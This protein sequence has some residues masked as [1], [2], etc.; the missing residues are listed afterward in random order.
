MLGDGIYRTSYWPMLLKVSAYLPLFRSMPDFLGERPQERL[1]EART[2]FVEGLGPFL[3]ARDASITAAV[4]TYA[5]P[6]KKIARWLEAKSFFA[7]TRLCDHVLVTAKV[8][9]DVGQ[10]RV[11]NKTHHIDDNFV[12][13]CAAL[14]LSEGVEDALTLS[15]LAFPGCITVLDGL[16]VSMGSMNPI[17]KKNA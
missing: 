1:L 17:S 6:P 3:R 5:A 12:R 16:A 2:R 15:E 11:I 13:C 8:Y 14:T 9:V 4:A 7:Q 10:L